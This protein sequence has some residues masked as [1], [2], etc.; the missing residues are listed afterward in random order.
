MAKSTTAQTVEVAPFRYSLVPVIREAWRAGDLYIIHNDVAG[1]ERFFIAERVFEDVF[2][3]T[4]RVISSIPFETVRAA[5]A[6]ATKSQRLFKRE[7]LPIGCQMT[8]SELHSALRS[9]VSVAAM[10]SMNNAR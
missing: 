1:E 9:I 5:Y 3:T 8:P 6:V 4:V 10:D 2:G 7:M